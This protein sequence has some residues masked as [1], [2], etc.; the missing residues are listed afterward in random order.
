MGWELQDLSPPHLK[1]CLAAAKPNVQMHPDAELDH[2]HFFDLDLH[3]LKKISAYRGDRESIARI[4]AE[5]ELT[6]SQEPP[7]PHAAYPTE[8]HIPYR[9]SVDQPIILVLPTYPPILENLRRAT[10]DCEPANK[11]AFP[12]SAAWIKILP[13]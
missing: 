2:N 4:G 7:S 13:P 10:N 5:T 9:Y 11:L 3:H 6:G 1:F 12:R 8:V